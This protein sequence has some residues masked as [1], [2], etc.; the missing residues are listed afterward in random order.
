MRE[1]Q[2]AADEPFGPGHVPVEDLGPRLEPVELA[3]DAAPEGFGV[4][5]GFFVEAL[6]VGHAGDMGVGA[7]LRWR[8]ENA[9]LVQAGL[10]IG[11]RLCGHAG[12]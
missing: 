7:E 4:A 11:G 6:V 3:R 8:R 12:S 9:L 1:I 5:V 2:L 10:D